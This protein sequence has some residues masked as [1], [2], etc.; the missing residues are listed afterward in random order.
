[1][2][3]VNLLLLFVVIASALAV[4]RVEYEARRAYAALD[5]ARQHALQLELDDERL[6]VEVRALSVPARIDSL[7]RAS[8][9]LMPVTPARTDYVSAA[10]GLPVTIPSR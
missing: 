4:V 8:L 7:A 6:Q 5:A 3:R 2:I 9:G 10:P 1:M